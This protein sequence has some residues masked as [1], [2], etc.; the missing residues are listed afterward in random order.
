MVTIKL[1][2]KGLF[3]LYKL[4][5][6]MNIVQINNFYNVHLTSLLLA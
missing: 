2:K 1:N 6:L 4:N 5:L 3:L